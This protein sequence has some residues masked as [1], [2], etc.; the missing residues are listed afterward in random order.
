MVCATFHERDS[1]IHR[2]DP[3]GRVVAGGVLAVLV[4]V[5]TRWQSVGAAAAA[6]VVLALMSRLP[7]R[8]TLKRLAGANVFI[9]LL[10]VML[11]L[12]VPGTALFALGDLVF[13]AEGLAWA[14]LIAVKCNT[15][16]LAATSLLSTIEP[17]TLGHAMARLHIPAKL[18]HLFFFTVRYVG[19]LGH[20]QAKLRCA[21]KVR[22]F[23]PRANMHTVR[24]YGYLVGML[25]VRSFDRSERIVAAMKC[26]G[27]NGTFHAMWHFGFARRDAVFAAAAAG[28]VL[29][30]AW[31]EWLWAIR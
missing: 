18:V 2:L 9:V 10:V 17:V 22:G 11:P 15:I 3:R 14:M 27:F 13:S 23:R 8:A 20:E 30:L 25:L 24:T 12:S 28:G 7:L 29:V 1:V 21:M 16:I 31:L 26:R 5:C 4:A 19:V 6:A